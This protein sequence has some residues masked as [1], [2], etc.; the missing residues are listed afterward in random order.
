MARESVREI[1]NFAKWGLERTNDEAKEEGWILDDKEV[2][3]EDWGR[4]GKGIFR[5]TKGAIWR[6]GDRGIKE[7][8]WRVGGY[9]KKD[10][11]EKH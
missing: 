7:G 2:F 3:K 1:G 10:L 9:D 6:R 11:G 4:K 8:C 5:K